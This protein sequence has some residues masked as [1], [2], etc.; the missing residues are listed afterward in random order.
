MKPIPLAVVILAA[1]LGTWW[2]LASD[3]APSSP[4]SEEA[5]LAGREVRPGAAP[6][7]EPSPSPGRVEG[8]SQPGPAAGPREEPASP[9][10][11]F[12]L[13]LADKFMERASWTEESGLVVLQDL[14]EAAGVGL[15]LSRSI[16]HRL[17]KIRVTLDLGRTPVPKLLDL[18]LQ[19]HTLGWDLKKQG[20]VV[21]DNDD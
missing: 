8:P 3:P 10:A 19:P 1:A 5:A 11:V 21:F 2:L 15:V 7:A 4:T 18:V 20:I 9:G 16:R 6:S 17:E 12:Q 13:P 14:S